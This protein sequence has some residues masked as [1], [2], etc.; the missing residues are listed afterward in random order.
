MIHVRTKIYRIYKMPLQRIFQFFKHYLSDKFPL[1]HHHVNVFLFIKYYSIAMQK[2]FFPQISTQKSLVAVE[3]WRLL[4]I[5]LPLYHHDINVFLFIKYYS[6]AMQKLMLPLTPTQ[7][8]LVAIEFWRLL[9]IKFFLYH[10]HIHALV[11][12]KYYSIARQNLFLSQILMF[13][14]TCIL[15][16][17]GDKIF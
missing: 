14:G 2:L 15:K 4:P 9:A 13:S 17:C 12:I 3:L 6:I 7:K 16:T 5:K 10:H 1:Y 11:F 8:S